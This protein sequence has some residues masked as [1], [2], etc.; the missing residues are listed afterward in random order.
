MGIRHNTHTSNEALTS[1]EL[2]LGPAVDLDQEIAGWHAKN[3]DRKELIEKMR[4]VVSWIPDLKSMKTTLA[5][6]SRLGQKDLSN[7]QRQELENILAALPQLEQFYA[8]TWPKI[9]RLAEQNR[10]FFDD[11]TAGRHKAYWAALPSYQDSILD[12]H[13]C[14]ID[15]IRSLNKIGF[16]PSSIKRYRWA[17]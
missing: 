17:A 11:T 9:E 15:V 7:E 3:P 1:Q 13:R 10:S 12:A 5:M 16:S 2:C 8:H 6:I 4:D 14:V